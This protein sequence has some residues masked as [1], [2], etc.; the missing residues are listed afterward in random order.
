MTDALKA[1]AFCLTAQALFVL[2]TRLGLKFFGDTGA[3]AL[4]ALAALGGGGLIAATRFA[5]VR[6]QAS[7]KTVI[8]ATF[9]AGLGIALHAALDLAGRAAAGAAAATLMAYA[10]PVVL[11]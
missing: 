2:R 4:T 1:I 3:L 5:E 11:V 10:A 7:L 6:G 9:A 8:L